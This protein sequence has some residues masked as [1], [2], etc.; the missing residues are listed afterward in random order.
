MRMLITSVI[1]CH[2]VHLQFD[3]F[4]LKKEEKAGNRSV[5]QYI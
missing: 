4:I 2:N 5:V 1:L 3:N